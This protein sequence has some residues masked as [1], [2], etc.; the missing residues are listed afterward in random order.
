MVNP[1][2]GRQIRLDGYTLLLELGSVS[3]FEKL[4]LAIGRVSAAY[5]RTKNSGGNP[6]KKLRLR[7]R[8]SDASSFF[9]KTYGRLKR[10]GQAG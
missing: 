2:K 5:R 1:E 10:I 4:R 3:D 8:W 7:M 9:G 6:T